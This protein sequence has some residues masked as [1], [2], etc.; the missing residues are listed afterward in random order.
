MTQPILVEV[1]T[2][3]KAIIARFRL[4]QNAFLTDQA[5]LQAFKEAQTQAEEPGASGKYD[6][7]I[8]NLAE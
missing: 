7:L 6:R 4:A 8:L 3:D 1:E 5:Y 2:K